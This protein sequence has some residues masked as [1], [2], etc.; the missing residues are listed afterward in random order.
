MTGW[1]SAKVGYLG[2][3]SQ[4]K[5]P[6]PVL[7]LLILP[8]NCAKHSLCRKYKNVVVCKRTMRSERA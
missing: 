8:F 5:S 4:G 1:Y 7:R 3:A 2:K 6:L